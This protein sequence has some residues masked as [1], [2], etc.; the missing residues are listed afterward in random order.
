MSTSLSTPGKAEVINGHTKRSVGQVVS[1]R[2]AFEGS[3]A[4]QAVSSRLPGAGSK[5]IKEI[6]G[7]FWQDE[8][9]VVDQV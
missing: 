5:P 6:S 2:D 8:D 4:S 3:G 9:E 1:E 7:I